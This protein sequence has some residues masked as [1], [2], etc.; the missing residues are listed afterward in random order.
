MGKRSAA[1]SAS[2][3]KGEPS[4]FLHACCL[5]AGV[6]LCPFA[7]VKALARFLDVGVLYYLHRQIESGDS[8]PVSPR[9]ARGLTH[10]MSEGAMSGCYMLEAGLG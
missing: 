3:I 8:F 9:L 4:F 10:S 1:F 6:V 7:E 5:I 2:G